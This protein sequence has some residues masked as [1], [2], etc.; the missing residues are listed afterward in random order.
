MNLDDLRLPYYLLVIAFLF[1]FG[2][3]KALASNNSFSFEIKALSTIFLFIFFFFLSSLYG[4]R[5]ISIGFGGVDAKNY[6]QIFFSLDVFNFSS[7]F[8]QRVEKG[9]ALLMWLTKSI[10]L[11]IHFFYFVF[12]ILLLS[13]LLFIVMET[14][15]TFF[16]IVSIG[17]FSLLYIDSFNI[18]RM[19][20]ATLLMLLALIYISK[21]K[22]KLGLFLV[23]IA[24]SFQLVA[25]WALF[26]YFY[27]KWLKSDFSSFNKLIVY[28]FLVFLSFLL[29]FLFTSALN[30]IG[31]SHYIVDEAAFSLVNYFV[32]F[33]F[34]CVYFVFISR[35]NDFFLNEP[36]RAVFLLLPTMFFILPIYMEFPIAYRF[37][38][39]YMSF[40]FFIIPDTLKWA[41]R[42]YRNKRYIAFTITMFP[43]VFYVSTKFYLYF[44][45]DIVYAEKWQILNTF[46]FGF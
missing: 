45:R 7:V 11:D 22:P 5:E 41:I 12:S 38:Y 20:F 42:A 35:D 40:F 6:E 3:H 28:F 2:G 31:Y 4:W 27:L 24:A 23:F 29:S 16:S 19:I 14:T 26:L 10:G 13:I 39:I 43:V 9:F 15:K 33:Y 37:N 44:T 8:E 18:S 21:G 1:L 32:C 25:I 34:C 46:T 36:V 17:L 30:F